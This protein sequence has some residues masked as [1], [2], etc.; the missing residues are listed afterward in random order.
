MTSEDSQERKGRRR[1]KSK[2][3]D[4]IIVGGAMNSP[5]AVT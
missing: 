2:D 4:E 3:E 5:L 1:S